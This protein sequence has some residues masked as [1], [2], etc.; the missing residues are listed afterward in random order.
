MRVILA[1][2]CAILC[3][4][5]PACA[6]EA[7]G[8][9]RTKESIKCLAIAMA[10]SGTEPADVKQTELRSMY[11]LGRIGPDVDDAFLKRWMDAARVTMLVPAAVSEAREKCNA[12]VSARAHALTQVFK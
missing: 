5:H 12:E 4:A 11:W 7:D 8:Q 1:G 6:E 3:L 10:G 9:S 2:A